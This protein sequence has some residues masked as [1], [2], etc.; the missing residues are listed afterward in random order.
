MKKKNK[1]NKINK[2][3]VLLKESNPGLKMIIGPR[4]HLNF[5]LLLQFSVAL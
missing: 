3:R 2:E 4:S 1:I 5:H